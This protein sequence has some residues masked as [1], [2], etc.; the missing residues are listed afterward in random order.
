MDQILPLIL[1]E[2]GKKYRFIF[3][4]E[5]ISKDLRHMT[6]KG[7]QIHLQALRHKRNS[8]MLNLDPTLSPHPHLEHSLAQ[9]EDPE[10]LI[11]RC[12]MEDLPM[13]ADSLAAGQQ[14]LHKGAVFAHQILRAQL[15]HR[16]RSPNQS[17]S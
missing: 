4:D 9:Q 7:V 10:S 15:R 8:T 13:E 11:H 12:V 6:D 5:G 3:M 1:P 14:R 17:D 16:Y 2:L